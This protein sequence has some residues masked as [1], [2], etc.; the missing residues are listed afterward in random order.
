MPCSGGGAGEDGCGFFRREGKEQD[1]AGGVE[2]GG[3]SL[4]SGEGP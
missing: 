3:G 2:G 1:E 4:G